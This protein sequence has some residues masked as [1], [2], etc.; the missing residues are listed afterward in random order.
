MKDIETI[1]LPDEKIFASFA[2]KNIFSCNYR[3]I[4]MN[5]KNYYVKKVCEKELI[6]ELLSALIAKEVNLKTPDILVGKIASSSQL[7]M[8]SE[9][10]Y[11]E[12]KVYTNGSLY[13][14][15]AYGDSKIY[16]S[17]SSYET[18]LKNTKDLHY[19]KFLLQLLK[20]SI[21]DAFRK[22]KDRTYG[23][24]FFNV[25]NYEDMIL[26]DHSASF[27]GDQRYFVKNEQFCFPK[28]SNTMIP[29][30]KKYPELKEMVETLFYFNMDDVL[31]ELEKVYHL[32]L[33]ES[34]KE[35]YKKEVLGPKKEFQRWLNKL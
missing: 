20:L 6:N 31:K 9:D 12:G 16:S 15:Q 34:S 24:Y 13:K 30:L 1:K 5:N 25:Q 33:N 32:T 17:I 27:N 2:E 23:N 3:I 21:Y 8:L 4:H 28:N 11:K 22:E 14:P 18:F 29:Y 19:Q 26:L 7:Y 10:F 35:Y